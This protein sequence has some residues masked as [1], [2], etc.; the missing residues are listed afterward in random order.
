[1]SKRG[2][3]VWAV[4]T[5]GCISSGAQ[6]GFTTVSPPPGTEASHIQ[7]LD[8]VYGA[9]FFMSGTGV[10]TN[11]T[12]TATRVDDFVSGS[13]PGSDL[14]LVNGAP[15]LP[16]T[17]QWWTDGIAFTSAEAK[18][19]GYNQEFGYNTGS[20]Y[21]KLFDVTMTGPTG[22]DVSGS[23]SVNF[24]PGSVFEWIRDGGGDQASSVAANNVDG[25]DHMVTYAITSPNFNPDETV[26]F[27]LWE[28]L[29]GGLGSGSDRDFNDL[30]VE[31]RAS[32]IPLP[33]GML[34]GALGL[35]VVA[36]LRRRAL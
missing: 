4:I 26:W 30:G 2:M 34:L 32:I 11:G 3:G 29:T 16:N 27:V 7:I 28:D 36:V 22:Y 31:L 17:D 33:G 15:G 23:G 13:S 1:M 12:V 5:A 6:A 18:F 25:L 8:N 35:G 9:G 20:G 14:H 24:A 19:A 21:Q 10:F